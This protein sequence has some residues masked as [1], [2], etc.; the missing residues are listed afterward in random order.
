MDNHI[1][2]TRME[3]HGRVREYILVQYCTFLQYL[4]L[5]CTSLLHCSGQQMGWQGGVALLL[6]YQYQNPEERENLTLSVPNSQIIHLG[7]KISK[8]DLSMSIL[9]YGNYTTV[10]TVIKLIIFS[11]LPYL[12]IVLNT[13]HTRLFCEI[14]L[15]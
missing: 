7:N 14:I 6:N 15:C 11:R 3:N 4:I 2:R 9:W 10:V 5:V 1:K 13:Y 12:N 8:L